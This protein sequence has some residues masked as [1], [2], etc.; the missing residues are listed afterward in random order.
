MKKIS[1]IILVL[2]LVIVTGCV[3]TKNNEEKTSNNQESNIPA[4]Y[5]LVSIDITKI[6]DYVNIIRPDDYIDIYLKVISNADDTNTDKI[7][8]GKLIENV[9]VIKVLDA[10]G[11]DVFEDLENI[12][13]PAKIVIAI[14]EE[15]RILLNKAANIKDYDTTLIPTLIDGKPG[16]IKIGNENIK[17]FVESVSR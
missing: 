10:L 2:L 12:L 1:L 4:D 8:I 5:E 6:K 7:M 17:L 14:P 13:T 16:P 3:N 15:Y 11:N 9:K